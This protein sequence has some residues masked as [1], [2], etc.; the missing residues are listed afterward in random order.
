MATMEIFHILHVPTA[1]LVVFTF[2]VMTS[3]KTI[4]FDRGK[5]QIISVA[6]IIISTY[7]SIIYLVTPWQ[8]TEL[9]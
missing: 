2:T 1:S 8:T 7:P 4:S 3:L 6:L 9:V 5:G